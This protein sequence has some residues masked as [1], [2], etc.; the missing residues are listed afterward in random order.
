MGGQEYT[1]F[2]VEADTN[3]MGEG[4]GEYHKVKSSRDGSL[5]IDDIG[6]VTDAG[7]SCNVNHKSL[8]AKYAAVR[9]TIYLVDAGGYQEDEPVYRIEVGGGK[10]GKPAKEAYFVVDYGE[11]DYGE[12]D[13]GD[14]DY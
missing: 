1:I 7:S 3:F 4:I 6:A 10:R 5:T 12:E 8:V 11:E 9:A 14:D 13:Y 2:D